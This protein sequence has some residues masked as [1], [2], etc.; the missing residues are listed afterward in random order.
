MIEASAWP[1]GFGLHSLQEVDSTMAEAARLLPQV[2]GP[3]WVW[4][5]HQTA[6]R[7]RRGR[8]WEMARDN[9]SA[10]V[11]LPRP[12]PASAMG[13]RSFVASLALY[14]AI[15]ALTGS[16]Q[17]ALK[18]PNDVLLNGGKMAGIL[19]ET[20]GEALVIG[21]GVNLAQAPAQA[22][23]ET[24]ALRPV[25]LLGE[26]GIEITSQEFLLALAQAFAL[27]EQRFCTYGFGPVR[28]AWLA[29]AAKLGEV[30]RVR[31][32]REEMLGTFETVDA[33]GHL[34]VTSAA[35]RQSIPAAD[36]FF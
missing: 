36:V 30:I 4:A 34:V 13:L 5:K 20:A 3:T 11:I 31:T 24:G 23:V 15:T 27:W 32:M 29:R 21:I 2:A 33:Q 16:A 19:L 1:T 12:G 25:S 35:G 10:S 9:F 14:D 22:D 6:A 17:L 26:L 28:E 7:G 8:V 18:W